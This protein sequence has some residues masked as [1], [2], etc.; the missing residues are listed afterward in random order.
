MS[1]LFL[2]ENNFGSSENSSTIEYTDHGRRDRS[3]FMA[4]GVSG[5]NDFLQEKF[6]RPTHRAIVNFR[7]PLDNTRQFFDAH[8]WYMIFLCIY[9]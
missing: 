3:L 6:S 2:V 1:S 8:S 5:S 9:G 7:G 4:G